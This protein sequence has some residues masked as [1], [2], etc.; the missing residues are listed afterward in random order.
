MNLGNDGITAARALNGNESWNGVM[1]ALGRVA[2]EHGDKALDCELT[3]RVDQTA[4]ARALRDLWVALT[5]ATAGVQPRLVE[6]PKQP[7]KVG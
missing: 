4:Y 7:L 3:H 6:K 1:A 5:A 2:A